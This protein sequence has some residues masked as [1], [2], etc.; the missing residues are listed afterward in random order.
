M[1]REEMSEEMQK[2]IFQE[3]K[4]EKIK[5]IIKITLKVIV[6]IAVLTTLFFTY[7]TYISTVKI[8][9]REY[10]ITNNKIPDNFNG[11]KILQFSDLH[12]GSTMFDDNLT[13]EICCDGDDAVIFYTLDGTNPAYSPTRLVYHEPFIVNQSTTLHYTVI[14]R[15]GNFQ[16]TLIDTIRHV[17]I[18]FIKQD[19]FVELYMSGNI[20]YSLDGSKFG[21]DVGN[22]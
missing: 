5:K 11:I 8:Q 22:N 21:N 16:K 12:Y 10:R 17:Y 3:D 7:T 4:K 18:S 19:V 1:T 9:V 2:E 20:Y 14:N 13:V 15:W 6:T